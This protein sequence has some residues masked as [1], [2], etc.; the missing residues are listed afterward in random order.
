MKQKDIYLI[1]IILLLAFLLRTFNVNWDSGSHLHPDE[2]AIILFTLPL[3]FPS[4]ITDF[5]SVQSSLNPHFF[6]YGSFPLYLLKSL[7]IFIGMFDKS[8]LTYDKINLLGRVFSAFFDC[9]TILVIFLLGKKLFGKMI[10]II[11]MIFYAISVLPIQLSH[12]YAVDTI[13]TLLLTTM[14]LLLISFYE[15]PNIKK[16]VFIG[17]I[18]GLS[19]ATK[20]SAIAIVTSVLV[21]LCI[22]FLLIF[23]KTPHKPH[24]WLPYLP[25]VLVSFFIDGGIIAGVSFITF[26]ICEPYALIDFKTFVAQNMQQAAMTKDAFTFPYT[27]QYVG[28]IWYWYELKNIFLW[29]LGPIV[30]TFSIIGTIFVTHISL[31]KEKKTKWA[32]ELILIV[33]FWTYF[34]IVGKFAIGFMRYMLP[35]YPLLCL[36][37]GIV[38]YKISLF[39]HPL[40]KRFYIDFSY[41]IIFILLFLV[42]PISFLT[43]YTQ[44]NTRVTA[45]N[46]INLHIPK[47]ETLSIEHWDD[48]LPLNGQENYRMQTLELYNPD[49]VEKWQKINSQLSQ[50]DYIIIASNRLYV[51]LQKLTDCE[52]LYP[53][54]CYRQ[55]AQ[56]YKNLFNG[57]LGFEKIAEFVVF[58]TIP[59]LNISIDDQRAD[60]SFT[61]YD[62]P[63]IMIFKKI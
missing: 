52:H 44:P 37:G 12:F 15:K 63:K 32:Q 41:Y 10:G 22:D 49:S 24:M 3:H 2:R 30:G 7:S 25:K 50:T 56:N 6:A 13:V 34:F 51:P 62:H 36:F 42:W 61:V 47:G 33:F 45:T 21:T 38:F 19:L 9:C 27:L 60:E 39:L 18:F 35:L 48:S 46:W 5:F 57:S 40:L 58:P 31:K 1:V 43:I 4:S 17:I 16:L 23:I 28:K 59:F 26:L 14:I 8:Y 55:T 11:A 29:G 53:H 20:I 54:P